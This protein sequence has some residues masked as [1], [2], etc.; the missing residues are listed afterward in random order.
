LIGYGPTDLGIISED[1]Q[2][3]ALRKYL[4]MTFRFLVV[5]AVILFS[6][7]ATAQEI[8]DTSTQWF[9]WRGP[10]GDG[11]SLSKA[12]PTTWSETENVK[13]RVPVEGVGTSTPI[14]VGN[15]VFLLSALNTSRIDESL[16]K[17]E[18]QPERVFGIKYPNTFYKF[19]VICL[20]RETG[21]VKWRKV[22]NEIV[23]HE[24]HHGDNDFA[25]ASPV[26]DGKHLWCWFGSAG[27]YC[28]SVDGEQVWKRDLGKAYVGAS[29]GEGCS[30]VLHNNRLVIVRD[31][32]RQSTIH[33]INAS[34]G[35]TVWEKDRDE[36]NNWATP[37]IYEKDMRTQVIT[38]G[39]KLV[40][41]YDL[42]DGKIIWQCDGLTE[43]VTP[44]PVIHGN[45]VVCMSGYKGY[46][47]TS[48]PLDQTGN[49]SKDKKQ[50]WSRRESGSYVPSPVLI[51][52]RYYFLQSNTNILS[53]L[54][55]DNGE[56][57][58]ERQRIPGLGNVYASP[59]ATE[60]YLFF[61][62]RNGKTIVAKVGDS[63][64]V[65]ATNKLDESFDA[66]PALVDDQ[67]FLRGARHLYCIE[68]K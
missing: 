57:V 33:V 37:I 13:W 6:V 16:P 48:Y 54:D 28:Y 19:L 18:D 67:L 14:V 34:T 40:R 66:S 46:A 26:T 39:T 62:G 65:V 20:D 31:H 42:D 21:N 11:S 56:D 24:G 63:F 64:E 23:P 7:Q 44:C 61:R 53:C 55:A 15:N 51:G 9:Q 12:P 5:L 41:S 59:V 58:F 27:L 25:S 3:D 4:I 68:Q 43:N 47:V 49:L 38:A 36:P 50:L 52:K 17:P 60:N 32:Q 8:P 30:P 45:S 2:F 29:L 35:K 10:S 22:A 1:V